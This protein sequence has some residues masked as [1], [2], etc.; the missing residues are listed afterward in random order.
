MNNPLPGMMAAALRAQTPPAMRAVEQVTS[1]QLLIALMNRMD[2]SNATLAR[3]A[4]AV[5]HLTAMIERAKA[6]ADRVKP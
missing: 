2:A 3:I 5:E 4:D 1:E 6:E